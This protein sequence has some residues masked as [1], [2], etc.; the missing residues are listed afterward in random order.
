MKKT[1]ISRIIVQ[2]GSCLAEFLLE[3]NYEVHVM[4][5]RLSSFN[6]GSI[7]HIF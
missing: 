6:T 7:N 3:K 2:D 1:F 4:L 5:R